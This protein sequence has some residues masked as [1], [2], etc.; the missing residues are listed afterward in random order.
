MEGLRKVIKFF[1]IVPVFRTEEHIRKCV[2][3]VIDQSYSNFELILVDD[4]SPDSAGLIC[5][6][7]ANKDK[8]VH[9]IHKKNEGQLSARMAG[10]VY[11]KDNLP[12][13]NGFFLFL[14]SDD[15]F[16]TN[17]LKVIAD[18]IQRYDSDLLL[19]GMQRVSQGKVYQTISSEEITGA[20]SDKR[21]LYRIVFSDMAYNPMCRKAIS[22]HL[23]KAE[24]WRS[25]YHIRYGEDLLQSISIYKNC[26][27]AVFIEDILYNYTVNPN[28][29]TNSI[30]LDTVTVDSTVRRMVLQFLQEENVF[31]KQDMDAYL[32]RSRNYLKKDIIRICRY[33]GAKRKK[34]TIF[35][36]IIHDDYYSML[37]DL[38]NGDLILS[39]LKHERYECILL[40][41]Q[42]ERIL[43]K[44]Y[45][46]IKKICKES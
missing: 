6:E 11:V 30:S 29:V 36:K 43:R 9:V 24:D 5:D 2:D 7:Y 33:S 28:S 39:W 3:S 37:L 12:E 4:G 45:S 40:Y 31:S 19:F 20:V 35:H 25:L 16:T 8:R 21:E 46:V 34:K 44:L 38:S 14:D 13:E 32:E 10:I 42:I 23:L 1:I 22:C 15:Y 27:K 41:A 26:R 18:S 17:A